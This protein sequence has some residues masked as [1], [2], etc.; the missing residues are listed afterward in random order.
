VLAPPSAYV[1]QLPVRV[2]HWITALC[3]PILAVTGYLIGRPPPS[4]SGDSDG[5]PGRDCRALPVRAHAN[6][7]P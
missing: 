2:W 1:Y 6:R 4:L 3:I 7:S 5:C